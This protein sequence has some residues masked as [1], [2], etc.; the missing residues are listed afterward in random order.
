MAS[1]P[2]VA[3]G[4]LALAVIIAVV[5]WVTATGSV[6]QDLSI[7]TLC[8]GFTIVIAAMSLRELLKGGAE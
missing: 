4:V 3:L 6:G 5:F 8:V 2:R 7:A 1:L